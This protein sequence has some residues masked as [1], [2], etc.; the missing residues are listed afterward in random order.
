MKHIRKKKHQ[1]VVSLHPNK[2]I[3]Y[4]IICEVQIKNESVAHIL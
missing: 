4:D 2:D 3:K 1:Q